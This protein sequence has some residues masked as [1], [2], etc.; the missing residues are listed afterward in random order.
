MRKKKNMH[1]KETQKE[2]E[3][4]LANTYSYRT[5]QDEELA[6]VVILQNR[7]KWLVEWTYHDKH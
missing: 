7:E 1:T 5:N 6:E 2:S 3:N 4:R